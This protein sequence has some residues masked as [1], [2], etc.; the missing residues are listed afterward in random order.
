MN[1]P[2]LLAASG[3]IAKDCSEA[4]KAFLMVRSVNLRTCYHKSS[5]SVFPKNLVQEGEC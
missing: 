3:A 2:T 1:M 5:D 4:N